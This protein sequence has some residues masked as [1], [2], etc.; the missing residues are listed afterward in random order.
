M[1]S[2]FRAVTYAHER[3]MTTYADNLDMR[4][5]YSYQGFATIGV[6]A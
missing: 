4:G 5:T 3:E 2:T 6:G 1:V